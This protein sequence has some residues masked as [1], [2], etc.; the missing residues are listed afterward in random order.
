[1]AADSP[2]TPRARQ[3]SLL[4]PDGSSPV[5]VATPPPPVAS[6][7][8]HLSEAVA[9]FCL[10]LTNDSRAPHTVRSTELDLRGL[11]EHLGDIRLADIAPGQLAAHVRWLRTD[12]HNGSSSLRRKIATLKMFFRYAMHVGWLTESPAES[13]PYPPLHRAPV[14][15]LSPNELESVIAAGAHDPVWHALALLFAD[16]GL[17]RDEVLALLAEDLYLAR[18]PS[19][20]RVTVR[21]ASQAKRVR[22]RSVPLTP[23]A[24]FALARLLQAPLPGGPLFS[25]SV[26][27]VNFVVETL[28]RRAQLSRIKKLT[29]DILRDT[30]AVRTV[31]S[32]IEV[33]SSAATRGATA[34]QL[35]RLR[36]QH[37]LQL[38]QLLGLSRYSDM[39][40]RY[41]AAAA[42][43]SPATPQPPAQ[44]TD[45]AAN[46]PP[47]AM[48]E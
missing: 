17:K 30:F 5:A 19:D 29:P 33:E 15:A 4:S 35:D 3:L 16:A 39:A 8:G 37:D 45:V 46:V 26:R 27:G 9:A 10:H 32:Q 31:Q 41:R 43:G 21:H 47:E 22:R 14:V 6:H 40:A 23:R 2:G 12:R 24:H 11:L 1:M 34:R 7:P 38:L 28:G 42:A 44:A 13:V 20:S 18:E 48:P 25:I 36:G